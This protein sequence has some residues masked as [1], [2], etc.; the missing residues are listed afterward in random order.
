MNPLPLE[1]TPALRDRRRALAASATGRVLDLGG[2]TDHLGSYRG[3]DVDLL[4]THL[5]GDGDPDHR[6]VHRLDVGADALLDRGAGSYDTILSLVRTPLVA[7]TSRFLATIAALLAED[8]R[9]FLLEPVRR[10][11][12]IGRALGALGPLVRATSGLHLD[13]DVAAEVRAAGF[14]ITDLERFRVPTV[15]APLR[16]FMEARA[17]V[18]SPRS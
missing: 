7:D 10:N 9:L 2:W 6:D 14:D 3:V 4:V 1:L 13:R 17:R 15:A 8:G 18:R 16:P 11:D 5:D 12:T